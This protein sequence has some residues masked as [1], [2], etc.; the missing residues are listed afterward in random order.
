VTHRREAVRLTLLTAHESLKED[1]PQVR[2]DLLAKDPHATLVGY[3][4]VT[5]LP[6]VVERLLEGGMDPGTP[7]AMV[8]Q[9]TTSSQRS[10]ISTLSQLPA[11]VVR[12]ELKPPAL[13]VIGP[14][15]RHASRL[16]WYDRLPL[17]GQRLVVPM[18]ARELV[19]SLEAAGADVVAVPNPVTP[20]ARV[21]MGT[22]PLT[23]C[24]FRSPADVE[25]LDEE[26]EQPGWDG[27]MT[28]W[29]LG[30]E[31]AERARG[32]GWSR[33]RTLEE[34]PDSAGLVESI[35]NS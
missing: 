33:I 22:A 16:D 10:V 4:G 18:A 12:E 3:M 17:A 7:A 29:C 27:E 30:K 19:A 20:A 9:G 28:A 25:S 6:Q 34:G 5:S 32:L 26:R 8:E 1:G 14:T 21:V 35:G 24:I 2:W 13:F 15:V 11:A 31:T 23:G